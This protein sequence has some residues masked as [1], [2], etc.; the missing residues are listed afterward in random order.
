M[1]VSKTDSLSAGP[2]YYSY[3][4]AVKNSIRSSR[5][6]AGECKGAPGKAEKAL[7]YTEAAA[8]IPVGIPMRLG[9]T[10]L[11]NTGIFLYAN[12]RHGKPE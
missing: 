3:S 9:I 10:A 4:D 7:C 12:M 2:K 11:A 8:E 6:I 1:T 5:E